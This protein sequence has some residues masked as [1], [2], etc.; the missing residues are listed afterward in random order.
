MINIANDIH[1]EYE[2]QPWKLVLPSPWGSNLQ[3]VDGVHKSSIQGKRL[4]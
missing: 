3:Q 2:F 4:P 1:F